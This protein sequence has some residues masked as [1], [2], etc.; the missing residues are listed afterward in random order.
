MTFSRPPAVAFPCA[1]LRRALR[2][3]LACV[4][5]LAACGSNAAQAQDA[6]PVIGLDIAPAVIPENV[7][8]QGAVGTMRRYF[9]DNSRA[10]TVRLTNSLA[11]TLG[12]PATVTIPSGVESVTFPIT[13]TDDSELNGTRTALIT[14]S[15]DGFFDTFFAASISDDESL[16]E[17][18]VAPTSIGENGGRATMTMRRAPGSAGVAE[19]IILGTNIAG[20]LSLPEKVRFESGQTTL[21]FDV[22][23]IDNDKF[24]GARTI[25]ISARR[26]R[27]GQILTAE[28]GLIDD[29]L[30][31]IL[32]LPP[33][34]PPTS[35]TAIA[36]NAS[37]LFATVSRSRAAAAQ[38]PIVVGVSSSDASELLGSLGVVM[39]QGETSVR[40]PLLAID[41]LLV[42]G[43]QLVTLSATAQGYNADSEVVSVT[44]NDKPALDFSL[45][46]SAASESAEPIAATGTL[47]RNTPIGEAVTVALRSSSARI[48]VPASVTIP[49]GAVE[50]RFPIRVV[51][52][53]VRD[54]NVN[55]LISASAAG[56][57]ARSATLGVLDNDGPSLQIVL[58]PSQVLEGIRSVGSP[59]AKGTVSR[60]NSDLSQP[61]VVTL[62]SSDAGVVLLAPAPPPGTPTPAPSP[63]AAPTA[64]TGP[65]PSGTPSGT[66]GPTP[67]PV[68]LP[69]SAVLQVT[70]EAGKSSASFVILTPDNAIPTDLMSSTVTASASGLNDAAVVVDVQDNDD[71]AELRISI[72]T[73]PAS[74]PG[75]RA[76]V[77]EDA[78]AGSIT[79]TVTRNTATTSEVIV[80]IGVTGDIVAPAAVVIPFGRSSVSFPVTPIDDERRCSEDSAVVATIVP[81]VAGYTFL[82]ED[83]LA[84]PQEGYDPQSNEVL[85][86]DNDPTTGC[87]TRRTVRVRIK[88]TVKRTPTAIAESDGA[89]AATI[90]VYRADAFSAEDPE[91]NLGLVVDL[92]SNVPERG[93][94]IPGLAR[95][96]VP[97]GAPRT[98]VSPARIILL[99]P[100][101]KLDFDGNPKPDGVV[102]YQ[103]DDQDK[104]AYLRPP[105]LVPLSVFNDAIRQGCA[106]ITISPVVIGYVRLNDLSRII[107]TEDVGDGYK[108]DEIPD[109]VSLLDNELEISRLSV[110]P[111]VV[112]E[113]GASGVATGLVRR[114]PGLAGPLVVTVRTLNAA[115]VGV[116]PTGRREPRNTLEVIIPDG[117]QEASF[118]VIANDNTINDGDITVLLEATTTCSVGVLR[119]PVVVRDND[120]TTIALNIARAPGQKAIIEGMPATGLLG[121]VQRKG[122][123]S[124]PLTITLISS[125]TTELVVPATVTIPAGRASM[126]FTPRVVDDTILDGVQMVT[127]RASST[128]VG[129]RQAQVTV[130]VADNEK[131][132]R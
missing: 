120:A 67:T 7:G 8:R 123:L 102:D 5:V 84:V 20:A 132:A 77:F 4:L 83:V 31:L 106:S 86:V 25:T 73:A 130:A 15:A 111:N 126:R 88:P 129:V 68:P 62:R 33:T 56:F 26:D 90:E 29:E 54:G 6:I 57:P 81:Q 36:E 112:N 104:R 122:D 45:N 118:N 10:L 1:S 103:Y 74:D 18:S 71:R 49:R 114:V 35:P 92:V 16:F 119:T 53:A 64:T 21:T 32:T 98:P 66:P 12:V 89:N 96:V 121:T 99:P 22:S 50:V 41:D 116:S 19:D 75:D 93:K 94:P 24:D 9:A 97:N 51:D 87:I 60:L 11:Q 27:S 95:N 61:L 128:T 14:A 127:V 76:F 13:V 28:L 52:N 43:A 131:P 70:I 3:W 23:A 110:S 72:T 46:T 40:V 101:D 58:V 115:K 117:Q 78:G 79:A 63:T 48:A 108:N 42:D 37:G 91:Y 124:R 38:G 55:V 59:A 39:R 105:A 100:Q 82:P 47:R 44:D 85:I 69:G 34:T 17:M 30:D 113:S 2:L 65:T 109:T 80:Q 125:D 107:P